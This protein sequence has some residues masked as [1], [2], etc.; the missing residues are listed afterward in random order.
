MTAALDQ[1]DMAQDERFRTNAARVANRD[2]L[3]ME[4]E[5]ITGAQTTRA[6][7]DTLRAAGVPVSA[8]N[9]LS[10]LLAEPLVQALPVVSDAGTLKQLAAIGT[11]I[12]FNGERS[13]NGHLSAQVGQDSR[14]VLAAGGLSQQDIAALATPSNRV[15]PS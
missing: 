6:V 3:H 8:V 10:K 5:A 4:L 14:D 11:P 9:D 1:A 7:V 2:A 12:R 13:Y 15:K